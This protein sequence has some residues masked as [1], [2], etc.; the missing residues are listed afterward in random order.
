LKKLLKFDCAAK[1]FQFSAWSQFSRKPIDRFLSSKEMP[2]PLRLFE[3]S[4][5]HLIETFSNDFF[6]Q[7]K[8]PNLA[9]LIHN[10]STNNIKL[11][12]KKINLPL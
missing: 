10:L 3:F 7:N 5:Y 6:R 4:T 2:Q 1:R 11:I 8:T 12:N 9:K